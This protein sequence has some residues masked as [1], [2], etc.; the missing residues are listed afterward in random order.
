MKQNQQKEQRTRIIV[1]FL[2]LVTMVSAATAIWALFFRS[3]E[4]PDTPLIPDYAPEIEDRAEVFSTDNSKK[5]QAPAKGSSVALAYSD[6]VTID[7][8][9]KTASL[10]FANPKKSN[11]D[12][13]LQI[14]VQDTVIAQTGLLT[15]GSQITNI[16][17]AD[18][19]LEKL[20]LGKYEGLF[21][22]FYYSQETGE[23]S[24]VSTE[25][26]IVISVKER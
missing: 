22:L 12:M 15:A 7:L 8:G 25:I 5:G 13:V 24:V 3:E 16:D 21:V 26:P 2:L 19:T 23:K 17:L 20:A 1:Y 11:Q 14:V 18:E 6:Q 9:E 10:F 4:S